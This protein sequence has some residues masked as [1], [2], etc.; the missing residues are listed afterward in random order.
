MGM[1]LRFPK[2][3]RGSARICTEKGGFMNSKGYIAKNR[4]RTFLFLF[5]CIMTT[6]LFAFSA[7]AKDKT[8]KMTA[9]DGKYTCIGKYNGERFIYTRFKVGTTGVIRVTGIEVTKKKKRNG[10]TLCLCNSDKER[11]DLNKVNYVNGTSKKQEIK[12]YV[13]SKGTYYFRIKGS[14][15]A[16]K[17]RFLLEARFTA[18]DDEAGDS[19]SGA[20]EIKKDATRNVLICA[21][22][23]AETSKWLYFVT[24]GEEPVKIGLYPKLTKSIQG[25]FEVYLYG[26][27][28]PDGKKL[29]LSKGGDVYT[30]STTVF[31]KSGYTTTKK[32]KG[33]KKGTYYLQI[34]RDQSSSALINKA[35]NYM[36]VALS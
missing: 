12:Y 16:K 29:T 30:L 1:M 27:A 9:N 6:L 20:V 8:Y 15:I 10:F 3:C 33:P 25:G 32:T 7:S 14:S 31:I 35:N 21:G 36:L 23:P 2:M 11:I 26:P 19:K 28:Y 18:V 17:S 24:D 13:L 5:I 22:A 4:G 34:I